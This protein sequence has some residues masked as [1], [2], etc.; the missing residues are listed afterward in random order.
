LVLSGLILLTGRNVPDKNY[1]ETQNTHF[2]LNN[3]FF[4][5]N[6]AVCEIMWQKYGGEGQATEDNI[7]HAHCMLDT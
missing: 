2:E 5:E 1:K 6:F 7:E 3:V 4:F